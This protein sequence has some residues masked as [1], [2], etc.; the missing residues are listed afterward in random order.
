[1]ECCF[2]EVAVEDGGTDYSGEVKENKLNRDDDLDN[3][4]QKK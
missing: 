2:F 4:S 3:D 1:M